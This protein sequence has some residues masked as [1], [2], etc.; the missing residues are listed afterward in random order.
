CPAPFVPA[1]SRP[2]QARGCSSCPCRRGSGRLRVDDTHGRSRIRAD[3]IVFEDCPLAI[4]GSWRL[5]RLAIATSI[6][7]R[8]SEPCGTRASRSLSKSTRL[9]SSI[10]RLSSCRFNIESLFADVLAV[11][12][13]RDLPDLGG[14]GI[15]V[16]TRDQLPPLRTRVDS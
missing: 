11:D 10:C 15:S 2:P 6:G 9:A 13:R 1:I 4:T 14:A 7:E 8:F 3:T 5:S 16:H 12:R